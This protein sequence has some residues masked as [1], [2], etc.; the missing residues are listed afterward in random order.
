M[1]GLRCEQRLTDVAVLPDEAL[2]HFSH[3]FPQQQRAYN[4]FT[5][6]EKVIRRIH[7]Y[8]TLY[9]WIQHEPFWPCCA[10]K[11]CQDF[12]DL[13]WP[14]LQSSGL[15][16][17]GRSLLPNAAD[18][19]CTFQKFWRCLKHFETR[20]TCAIDKLKVP[21]WLNETSWVLMQIFVTLPDAFKSLTLEK[22]ILWNVWTKRAFNIFQISVN[23]N[24]TGKSPMTSVLSDSVW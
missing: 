12:G 2:T 9:K 15:G 22:L 8:P 7:T 11:L 10:A 4:G 3:G 5:E 16:A 23:G 17:Y 14:L 1:C 24:F 20:D 19:R 6:S 13:P 21:T 18:R